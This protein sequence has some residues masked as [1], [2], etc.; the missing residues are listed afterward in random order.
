MEDAKRKYPTQREK[1]TGVYLEIAEYMKNSLFMVDEA[2]ENYIKVIQFGKDYPECAL[3]SSLAYRNLAE[4][5]IEESLQFLFMKSKRYI[6]T[7]DLDSSIEK[8]NKSLECAYRSNDLGI[9]Q[10]ALHQRSL[11]CL[12]C[13]ILDKVNIYEYF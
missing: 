6:F 12:S 3:D 13:E 4:I 10:Q 9:I 2:K 7:D 1:I 8:I 11:I 5:A